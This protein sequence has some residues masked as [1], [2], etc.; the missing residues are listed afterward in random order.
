MLSK[1]VAFAVVVALGAAAC[2]SGHK[3]T[4]SSGRTLTV[5]TAKIKSL[6]RGEL[7]AVKSYDDVIG[8]TNEASWKSTFDRIRADHNAAVAALRDRV[9]AVGAT[10]DDS[11]GPWGGFAEAWATMGAT[12]SDAGGRDALKAGEKHGIDEYESA[13]KSDKVDADTKALITNTLL[14]QTRQHVTDL[15]ALKK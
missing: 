12:I 13:L 1:T 5:D 7:S 3:T 11:A 9:S 10:P 4:D 15:D 14:P 6:H 2:D 8:K